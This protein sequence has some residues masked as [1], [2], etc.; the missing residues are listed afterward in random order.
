MKRYARIVAVVVVLGLLLSEGVSADAVEGTGT[1]RAVGAG[2]AHLSGSG[3]VD[4]RALGAGT[5]WV[6]G[7]E[8]L[9]ASGR[10]IRRDLP[11]GVA[12]LAG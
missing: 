7:A 3:R 12:F 8:T 5:I 4:I 1:L 9:A 10:G 6:R 11:G 2:V